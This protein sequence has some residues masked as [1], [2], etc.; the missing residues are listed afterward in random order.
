[1][2]DFYFIYFPIGYD[3]IQTMMV[4]FK[5]V[6]KESNIIVVTNHPETL[7]NVKVDF[8][9]IVL[10]LDD[11]RDDWSK[12]NEIII[13][14]SM[15]LLYKIMQSRLVQNYLEYKKMELLLH[16]LIFAHR[17]FMIAVTLLII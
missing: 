6:P 2:K 9:L 8:N 12:K 5:H 11:L 1:M 15:H 13:L 17:Y 16:L 14:Q 7:S 3:F 10:N 4:T